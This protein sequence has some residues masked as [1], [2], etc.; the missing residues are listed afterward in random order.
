MA[1]Q[2]ILNVIEPLG[3]TI[4]AL[5][6]S[7][8]AEADAAAWQNY[9]N[10]V[11]G[12]IE[13]HDAILVVPFNDIDAATTFAAYAESLSNYRFVAVCYHGTTQ[14]PQLSASI[15]AAMASGADPAVPFDD[16]ELPG[17]TAVDPKF[18][19]TRSRIEQALNAGVAV[20]ATGDDGVPKIVRL[21]TTYQQKPDGTPDTIMLDV[22][23]PLV[24]AYVRK[25][26]R[27]VKSAFPRQKNTSD[28]R[29]TLRTALLTAYMALE[30]AEIL[31][32]VR[33]DQNQLTV[34]Q[35]AQDLTQADV[36]V[37]AHWVRGMHVTA[38]TLNVY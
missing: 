2:D 15:A 14:L 13:Q 32:D 18:T 20:V 36:Q 9:L 35:D 12:P 5:D 8:T 28:A 31:E 29:S 11:S 26:T 33:A 22:N 34:A 38:V 4:I 24:L 6:S 37:P 16:I 30:D 7:I 17:L 23:G 10:T 19:L 27:A 21:I 1:L 3:H 25:V